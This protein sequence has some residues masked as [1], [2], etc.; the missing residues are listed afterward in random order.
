M[1]YDKSEID[2]K[3]SWIIPLSYLILFKFYGFFSSYFTDH[4]ET[5]QLIYVLNQLTFS[6]W[7][8]V[9]LKAGNLKVS[10]GRAGSKECF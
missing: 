5:S 2:L 8:A 6:I 7:V 9:R 1:N 4:T 10:C 3:N